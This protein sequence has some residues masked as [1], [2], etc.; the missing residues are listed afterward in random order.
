MSYFTKRPCRGILCAIQRRDRNFNNFPCSMRRSRHLRVV[1]SMQKRKK[2]TKVSSERGLSTL[3]TGV[4]RF[5]RFVLLAAIT[6]ERDIALCFLF[7]F[8][9]NTRQTD[10]IHYS[11]ATSLLGSQNFLT[12]RISPSLG[13]HFPILFYP[14]NKRRR[15]GNKKKIYIYR[16]DLYTDT[17]VA[18][19]SGF[20]YEM[21]KWGNRPKR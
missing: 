13:R 3:T 12:F 8:V 15:V 14:I 4:V 18:T 2:G 16:N 21:V 19:G 5:T 7:L 20:L 6:P 9:P 10:T 11:S 17:A 1:S